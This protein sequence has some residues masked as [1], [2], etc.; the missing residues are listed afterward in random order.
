[1]TLLTRPEPREAGVEHR[2]LRDST[3][4]AGAAAAW[5]D[6]ETRAGDPLTYFQSADWCLKWIAVFGGPKCRPEVHTLWQDGR[7]IRIEYGRVF[8]RNTT[9]LA[10]IAGPRTADASRG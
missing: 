3:A 4:M 8:V 1:M 5:R 6:L 10:A 7:L 2:V 9:K